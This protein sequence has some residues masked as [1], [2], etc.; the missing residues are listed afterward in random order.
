[1]IEDVLPC[2]ISEWR[3]YLEETWWPAVRKNPT[4]YN[5]WR[6]RANVR[7]GKFKIIKS[8]EQDVLSD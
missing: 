4:E 2:S 3:N 5:Y 6:S 8:Q 7:M 1:M